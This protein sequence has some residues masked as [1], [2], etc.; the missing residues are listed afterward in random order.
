MVKSI[1]TESNNSAG[2]RTIATISTERG[3]A[4]SRYVATRLMKEQGLV[5]CQLPSHQ[6][7][8]ATQELLP[9]RT[10]SIVSLPRLSQTKFGVV[11]LRLFGR[12]IDGLILRL[13]WTYLHVN[14]LVGQCLIHLIRS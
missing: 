2:A 6:Y 13:L 12:A 11:I 14:L 9:Y 10:R 1:Y 5:S 4:L 8:K 7:K 3:L